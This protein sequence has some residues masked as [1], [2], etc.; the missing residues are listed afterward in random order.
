MNTDSK[1][2]PERPG[3]SGEEPREDRE[4]G[5]VTDAIEK[6][7]KQLVMD[8]DDKYQRNHAPDSKRTGAGLGGPGNFG[9]GSLDSG[10][11]R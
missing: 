9:G 3:R 2:Q 7:M 4:R 1:R 10:K 8:L 6:E 11:G 5:K